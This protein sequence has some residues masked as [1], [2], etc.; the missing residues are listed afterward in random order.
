MRGYRKKNGFNS[1][2]RV[3][4]TMLPDTPLTM[5]L[6]NRAYMQIILAGR[7]TLEER[8]AEIDSKEVR[9]GLEQ[10]RVE[11]STVH[12]GIKKILR[13][14]DLPKLVVTLLEQAAS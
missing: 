12:P 14:P 3:I 10:S 5:N 11:I 7:E 8:F 2:E 9:L 6:K 4:K 1:V 13:I